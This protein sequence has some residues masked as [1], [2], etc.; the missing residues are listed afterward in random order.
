MNVGVVKKPSCI[1][2]ILFCY[3]LIKC[4]GEIKDGAN[5][6]LPFN[7]LCCIGVIRFGYKGTTNV[8]V[9]FSFMNP[10]F[11]KTGTDKT[12][13]KRVIVLYRRNRTLPASTLEISDLIKVGT[14]ENGDFSKHILKYAFGRHG[15]S[16][17]MK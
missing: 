10:V 11:K 15:F 9:I 1:F 6:R 8:N 3:L 16:F 4:I 12:D 13:I 17:K 5:V 7:V 2:P 14:V